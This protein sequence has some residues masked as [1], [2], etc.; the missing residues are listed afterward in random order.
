MT[1]LTVLLHLSATSV[2][3]KFVNK[4]LNEVYNSWRLQNPSSLSE[5]E[6]IEESCSEMMDLYGYEKVSG[7]KENFENMNLEFV[8][9]SNVTLHIR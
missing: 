3:T 4:N 7:S 8:L 2:S 6:I 1:K 9:S 5:V